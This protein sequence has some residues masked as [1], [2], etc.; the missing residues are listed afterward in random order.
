MIND[1]LLVMAGDGELREATEMQA[2]LLNLPV[3]CLGWVANVDNLLASSNLLLMTSR[4]EGMPVVIIEAAS[5]RV[6]TLSTDVG[7]VKDFITNDVTG[8]LAPRSSGDIA[9]VLSTLIADPGPTSS[10]DT[11]LSFSVMR[12]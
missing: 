6:A 12:V 1:V 4:N 11:A 9:R 10:P 5:R 8:F 3:V 2:K 7:G